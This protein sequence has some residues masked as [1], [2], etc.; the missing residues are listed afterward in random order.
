MLKQWVVRLPV[1]L[2]QRQK[3]GFRAAPISEP[4]RALRE[5]RMAGGFVSIVPMLRRGL[6]GGF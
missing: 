5:P 2:V 3:V 4:F 1:S 6:L